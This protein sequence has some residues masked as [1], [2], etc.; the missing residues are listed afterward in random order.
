[1]TQVPVH[2]RHVQTHGGGPEGV[3]AGNFGPDSTMDCSRPGQWTNPGQLRKRPVENAFDL[4]GIRG[5]LAN[6]RSPTFSTDGG[7][8]SWRAN[9]RSRCHRINLVHRRDLL[10]PFNAG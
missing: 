10:L 9:E 3:W 4:S 6:C 1:M 5:R 2:L 8:T 7:V